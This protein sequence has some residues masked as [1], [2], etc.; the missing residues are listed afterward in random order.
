MLSYR[1]IDQV[2][3]QTGAMQRKI[4]GTC[5]STDTKPTNVE[6]G[7]QLVEMD[8]GLVYFFDEENVR[9]IQFA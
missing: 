1:I 5:L 4:D 3:D 7:S 6:N 2:L 9:W 8:T